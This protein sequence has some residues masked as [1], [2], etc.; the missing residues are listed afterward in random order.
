M[1]G[2][3][4]WRL[5]HV[6]R[7]EAIVALALLA[8]GLAAYFQKDLTSKTVR[9]I[10]ADQG[11]R[12]YSYSYNDAGSGGRSTVKEIRPL[13]WECL[14]PGENA[15]APYCGFGMDLDIAKTGKGL[16][17]S[18]L[19]SIDLTIEY[20]GPVEVVHVA[21]GDR[22]PSVS[23]GNST[24]LVKVNQATLPIRSGTQTRSV[25]RTDFL[26]PQWWLDQHKLARSQTRPSLNNVTSVEII[27]SGSPGPHRVH[28]KDVTFHTTLVSVEAWYGG[29]AFSWIL[30]ISILLPR[31]RRQ[32]EIW[33]RQFSDRTLNSIPQVIWSIGP[34]GWPDF[35]SE[36]WRN[37]YE[38]DPQQLLGR[39]W[40]KIVHPD[41][42]RV[43]I[44]KW[45]QA[46]ET[47]QSYETEYRVLL[48]DGSYRWTVA[49]ARPE[50]DV[51][52]KITRWYG[53]CTD[54]HDRVIAVEALQASERLHRSILETSADCIGVLSTDGIVE[55]VNRPGVTA[56]ELE[57]AAAIQGKPFTQLWQRRSEGMVSAALAK[58]RSG[59]VARFQAYCPTA[60]GT[61][62][63]WDVVLT[64]M[65]DEQGEVK[66]I[67]SISRDITS[68]HEKSEQLRWASE[69]DA[70]TSLP[71]RRAFQ[72]RLQAV[73]LRA[74][75]TGGH[76]GL[77][78]IDLD[79]F[80]HVNDSLG[81][82]A[83]D[84]VLRAVAT[85]LS[86]SVRESDFVARVGGDEFAVILENVRSKDDVLTLGEKLSAR[87]QKS[88]RVEHR[89]L[90]P[91]AS[92]GGALFPEDA[93]SANDLFKTAD[94]ALY[95]LKGAGRGGTKLFHGYMLE[96]A[97]KAATQLGLARDALTGKT[98][99]P[100]YQQKVEVDSGVVVGFEALLRWKHP[101]NGLQLPNTVEEAFKDYELSA[102][103]GELMQR[104][105]ARDVRSW[106][107]RGLQFGHVAINAAPAEFLRDDYAERLLA[108]LEEHQVPPTYIEVEVTEHALL[109]QGPQ[110][111]ARALAKLKEAGVS[112]SLD[113][114]GTGYSS[115]A[116]LRDFS[117]DLVKIDKSFI[118]QMIEDP[119]IGSIVNAVIS[120]ARSINIE[121]VAEGVET[122][123]QLSLLRS[124]GC[125]LA[126]GHLF[127]KAVEEREIVGLLENRRAAA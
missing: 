77:L 105:V 104:A 31:R 86:D 89:V 100:V 110:H 26:V 112:V 41:D 64:P 114:F 43:A 8:T 63:W 116:H 49:R 13:Q 35:V 80:K 32:V 122:P 5:S 84:D 82:S 107:S 66:G 24:P 92:I 118:D 38:G 30:L 108:I 81:H 37:L 42:R 19:E 79:H 70:L 4:A 47:R 83:G 94:T 14:I 74:M 106:L 16:D 115:L 65:P 123:D 53:S 101:I 103:I 72:A 27:I 60:K 76:I 51:E 33:K 55:L 40:L 29:I 45:Q 2:W 50:F 126:Q 57:T 75:Q 28:L 44:Q 69:H 120:L 12:F 54:A 121:V 10:P 61:P 36:Q 119:E 73:T 20:Q 59:D 96:K 93:Q 21:L 68:D 117:V 18:R 124:M 67:L 25:Q 58:A 95:A 99:V 90:R 6:F 109:E 113:D 15:A 34:D 125:K 91:G 56:T 17:L 48:A 62:K 111:V 3:R 7:C 1:F 97:E 88:I 22:L 87:I 52:G 9:L 39:G 102:K 71:N 98:V 85:R 23:G 46:L 78:L 11:S 127:G